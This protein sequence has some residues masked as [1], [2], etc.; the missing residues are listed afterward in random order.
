MEGEHY[1]HE[2]IEAAYADI[3]EIIQPYQVEESQL[4]QDNLKLWEGAKAWNIPP[5]LYQL[6][7]YPP[8]KSPSRVDDKHDAAVRMIYPALNDPTN[9]LSVL[10]NALTDEVLVDGQGRATGVFGKHDKY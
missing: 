8:T 5:S 1:S 4:N 6:N 2:G 9:P 3:V 10:A 7:R